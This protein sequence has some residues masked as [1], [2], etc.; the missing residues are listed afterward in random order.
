MGVSVLIRRRQPSM[1]FEFGRSRLG[2]NR[3]RAA[4]SAFWPDNP[5]PLANRHRGCI[6]RHAARNC[7]RNL[8]HH[9]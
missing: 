9:R 3:S 1:R 2:P 6:A 5:E 4:E 8:P 7:Y